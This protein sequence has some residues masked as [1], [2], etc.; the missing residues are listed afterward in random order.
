MSGESRT[1]RT[2]QRLQGVAA[3]G[4]ERSCRP[5]DVS[6]VQC[7]GRVG[8]GTYTRDANVLNEHGSDVHAED[9][10]YRNQ[11]GRG[12]DE[13]DEQGSEELAEEVDAAHAGVDDCKTLV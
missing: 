8:D 11:R 9:G 12:C 6:F 4:P 1:E 5:E 7:N 10:P 2:Q 13:R 3:G